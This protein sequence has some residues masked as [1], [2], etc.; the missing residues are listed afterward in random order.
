LNESCDS[1]KVNKLESSFSVSCFRR[2]KKNIEHYNF[3]FKKLFTNLSDIKAF[4][5]YFNDI[6]FSYTISYNKATL[7]TNR[8]TYNDSLDIYVNKVNFFLIYALQNFE[9][10]VRKTVNTENRLLKNENDYNNAISKL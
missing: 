10:D 7:S 8:K 1:L 5:K 3:K 2:E 4:N 9:F 6:N